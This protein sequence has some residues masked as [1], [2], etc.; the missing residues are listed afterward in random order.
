MTLRFD[1]ARFRTL[2]AG[3]HGLGRELSATEVTDSTNDDA[4]A[5][6]AA[7]AADG[8][9]LVSDVQRA[10]RGRRGNSWLSV[11]GE[12]LLFSVLVRRRLPTEGASLVSLATGLAVRAAVERRLAAAGSPAK[13]LLKWPNDVLAGGLKLAG[14]LVESRIRRP[15]DPVTVIGVG[16]NLGRLPEEIGSI[17]TS[18]LALGAPDLDREALLRD[19][20]DE[21]GAR[22]HDL[23]TARGGARV[24][25]EL[26]RFDGLRGARV[27][28][29]GVVGTA[30]GIDPSG[31]L[32]ITEESGAV[33]N[34]R[35]GH[36]EPA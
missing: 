26:D 35:A 15:E 36:V 7:G 20:L 27:S 25:Q 33:H 9:V 11:Q 30:T 3:K 23:S 13:P 24:I 31:G 28:V 5:A 2:A 10:G 32:L 21:L 14:I 22:L 8:T 12:G 29:G 1:A 4:F 17:A 18:L 6:A 16:L 34:L 19:I